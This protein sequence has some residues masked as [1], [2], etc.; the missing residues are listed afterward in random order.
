MPRFVVLEHTWGTVHWDFML[1]VGGRLRTWALSAPPDSQEPIAAECLPDHRPMY[2][3]YEGPVSGDRGVVRRWDGGDYAAVQE[4][5]ERVRVRLR[6]MRLVGMAELER[7]Q[8][9]GSWVY[10]WRVAGADPE[11]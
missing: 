9:E 1:E 4:G 11:A 6:G 7:S 5:A 8:H 2:L 3:D 10:R